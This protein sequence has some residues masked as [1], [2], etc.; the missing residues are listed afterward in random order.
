[1]IRRPPRST[2][3]PYTTLFRSLG[4]ATFSVAG[5]TSAG[6][7]VIAV[8]YPTTVGQPSLGWSGAAIPALWLAHSNTGVGQKLAN[9]KAQVLVKTDIEYL[10]ED[11]IPIIVQDA[12]HA[13]A[14]S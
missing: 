5:V 12:Y 6:G 1:M 11:N 13:R 14:G 10:Q 8:L 4:Y 3:F 9:Y 7:T 2:L